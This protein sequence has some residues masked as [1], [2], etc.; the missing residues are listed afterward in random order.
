M[1]WGFSSFNAKDADKFLGVLIYKDKVGV[2]LLEKTHKALT[3]TQK[4]FV[5]VQV[6]KTLGLEIEDVSILYGNLK[7]KIEESNK[8]MVVITQ[9][10]KVKKKLKKVET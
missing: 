1:S 7:H 5:I 3:A 10:L 4:L 9:P 2:K 6:C 8:P